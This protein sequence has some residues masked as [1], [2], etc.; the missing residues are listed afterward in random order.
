MLPS[1]RLTSSRSATSLYVGV[2]LY[3][4]QAKVQSNSGS[5]EF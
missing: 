2:V 1:E 3:V 4:P 5:A